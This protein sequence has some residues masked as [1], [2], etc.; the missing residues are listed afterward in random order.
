[1]SDYNKLVKLL[2]HCASDKRMC[3]VGCDYENERHCREIIMHDAAAE[4]KRLQHQ[5]EKY[6]ERVVYLEEMCEELPEWKVTI[7]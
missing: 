6:H 5:L 1:M 4:I 3:C 7:H 2:L